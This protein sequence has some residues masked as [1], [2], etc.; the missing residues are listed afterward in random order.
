MNLR[1]VSNPGLTQSTEHFHTSI[2]F[3]HFGIASD[4]LGNIGGPLAIG[5]DTPADEDAQ[6]DGDNQQISSEEATFARARCVTCQKISYLF[7]TL[8]FEGP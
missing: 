1:E 7:L 5:D 6:W 8:S 4:R 2:G 3:A